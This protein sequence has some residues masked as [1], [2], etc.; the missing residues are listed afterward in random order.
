MKVRFLPGTLKCYS[1]YMNQHKKLLERYQATSNEEKPH[2]LLGLNRYWRNQLLYELSDEEIVEAL[3]YSDEDDAVGTLDILAPHRLE[4]ILRLLHSA[5]QQKL[6]QLLSFAPNTACRLVDSNFIEISK[7]GSKKE[8]VAKLKNHYQV[9]GKTPTIIID[10]K[11]GKVI[12]Q[13][14]VERLV[15]DEQESL[16]DIRLTPLPVVKYTL[17]QK[18]LIEKVVGTSAQ[19]IAV[20]DKEDRTLGIIR[21]K[22]LLRVL[23]HENTEDFYKFAGLPPEEHIYDSPLRSVRLRSKWLIVN[24]F[25]ALSASV[26]V[27]MFKDTLSQIVILAAFMPVV[28]GMGGNAGTQ[29]L[30]VMVRG[31]AMGEIKAKSATSV[32]AKELSAG[33]LNGLITGVIVGIVAAIWQGSFLLGVVLF[34]AMVT[35]LVVAGFFGA[36]VPLLLKAI[37][38]DPAVASS[39]FIT[40]ATDIIGFIAFLSLGTLLLV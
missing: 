30:A 4:G 23:E 9:T 1:G 14:P 15:L 20:V 32:I 36:F 37:R 39:I 18:R 31:L 35:N 33:F 21:T 10:G 6:R 2:F 11:N 22:N 19:V 7:T 3:S 24:L 5:K 8:L 25:T 38:I 28:A 12:G 17:D 29:T 34:L 27:S 40:T 16:K 13:L 26:V